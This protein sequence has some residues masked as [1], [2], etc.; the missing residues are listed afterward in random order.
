MR[1]GNT[2]SKIWRIKTMLDCEK[3]NPGEW[4]VKQYLQ[5][6]GRTVID[7]SKNGDYWSQGIDLIA[8]R[9]QRTEKI[10]VKYCFNIHRY[11]SF[12]IELI[13]NKEKGEPGWID[14]TKSDFIFYVDAISG[15]CILYTPTKYATIQQRTTT[16]QRNATKINTRP[17][18]E[19]SSRW[20]HSAKN[21]MSRPFL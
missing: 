5:D 11:H 1:D 9:G 8:L 15:D 10:E 3:F 21:T 17:P 6:T 14:Y 20:R 12:F 7:V 19:P 4:M 13:A 16:R 2:Y 18:L